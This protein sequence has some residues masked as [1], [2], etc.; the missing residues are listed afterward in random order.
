MKTPKAKIM[1]INTVLPHE[2]IHEDALLE[3]LNQIKKDG[4]LLRPIAID[5]NTKII[6][7]GHHRTEALKR[8]GC[9]YISVYEFD[10]QNSNIEMKRTMPESPTNKTI[11]IKKTL[12]GFIFPAKSTRHV[13][14]INDTFVHI[15]ELESI[16]SIKLSELF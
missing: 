1:G 13:V 4:K 3:L 2:Q 12:G 16:H 10:Y 15:S 6:I 5:K 14:K 11:L 7:D 9:R 8:L